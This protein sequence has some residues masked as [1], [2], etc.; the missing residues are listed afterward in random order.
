MIKQGVCPERLWINDVSSAYPAEQA[1]LSSMEGGAWVRGSN[2]PDDIRSIDR[3]SIVRLRANFLPGLSF[4][5]LFYRTP[6][7]QI[8]FPQKVYGTYMQAEAVAAFD[9]VALFGGEIEVEGVWEFRPA[10]DIKPFHYIR[11]E[12]DYRAGLPKGD[13]T[14]IVIK[15]GMCSNYG[16]LAQAVGT[17]GKP[18]TFAGPWHSAAITAGTRANLLRAAMRNP[19]AVVMFATDGIV[20]ERPLSLEVPERKTLGLWEEEEKPLGGVFVHSG[21]YC[22]FGETASKTRGFRPEDVGSGQAGA[23]LTPEQRKEMIAKIIL[24]TIP[25]AWKRSEPAFSF[26]IKLYATLGMSTASLEAWDRRGCW[27]N[28][29]RELKLDSAGSKR[30]LMANA[31]E[32]RSRARHLVAT[33]PNSVQPSL[34][35]D[36]DGDQ[37]LSYPRIPDWLDIDLG[38]EIEDDQEQFEIS[39][40]FLPY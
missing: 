25:A 23:S 12:F 32:R 24:E 31:A 15:K 18:P 28:A 14:G 4:Y 29:Q 16:K 21:V 22:F 30:I 6:K 7:G 20:S 36:D 27:I 9:F 19:T 34:C 5:P 26:P 35:I 11:E 40:G 1:A 17:V 33:I 13:L 38:E 3:L 37:R 39:G 2:Q 8:F 10:S